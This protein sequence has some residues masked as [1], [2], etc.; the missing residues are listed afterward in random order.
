MNNSVN[1]IKAESSLL[2]NQSDAQGKA[3]PLA[4]PQIISYSTRR[5][6]KLNIL[7]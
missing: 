7:K 2:P 4:S 3:D 6:P 1:E 5:A